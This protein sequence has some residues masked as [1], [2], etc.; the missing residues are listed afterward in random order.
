MLGALAV[1][2]A[3]AVL[4]V[5]VGGNGEETARIIGTGVSAAITSG[6]L[7]ASCKFLDSEKYRRTGLFV[8][9]MILVQFLLVLAAFWGRVWM[10]GNYRGEDELYESAAVFPLAWIPAALFF[11]VR[12]LRGGRAAGLFGMIGCALA[13]TFFLLATWSDATSIWRGSINWNCWEIGWACWFFAFGSTACAAG[14]GIDHRHWRWI[15]LAASVLSFGLGV[16]IAWTNEEKNSNL[17]AVAT[18]IAVVIGHANLLWLCKLKSRQRLLRWATASFAWIAGASFDYAVLA[19]VNEDLIW[20]IATAATICAGCGTVAVAILAAFNRRVTA[21]PTGEI[22]AGKIDLA[23]PICG[24]KQIMPMKDGVGEGNCAEC[25]L[26]ISIR[27]RA[28]R[29]PSCD[30]MLLMLKTDR[31]PECGAH[32]AGSPAPAGL[33]PPLAGA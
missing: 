20:R 9:A 26:I 15:G 18:T 22:D 4:G 33:L 13:L 6:L 21:R 19:N 8:M 1:S 31:C 27:A 11:H 16:N 29:C 23:C 5:L 14:I 32:V 2:G 10:S 7:L 24:K 12:Q 28:P 30:Y 3:L 17:F 25:G